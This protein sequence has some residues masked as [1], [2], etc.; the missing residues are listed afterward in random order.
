[1]KK[2]NH[3]ASPGEGNGR[4]N[5]SCDY[6]SASGAPKDTSGGKDLSKN[7]TNSKGKVSYTPMES[8]NAKKASRNQ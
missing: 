3:P 7:A 2:I 5:K 1:M 4:V 8:G 6:Y